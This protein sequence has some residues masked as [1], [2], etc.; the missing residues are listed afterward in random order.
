[1]HD[2]T[3][4]ITRVT[5]MYPTVLFNEIASPL[6]IRDA[7]AIKNSVEVAQYK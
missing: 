1:M 6:N 5:I 7:A 2:R 3:A 4:P